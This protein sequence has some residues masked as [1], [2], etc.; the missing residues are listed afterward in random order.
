MAGS[1]ANERD[2]F[3]RAIVD[4]FRANRGR[5]GGPLAHTP[6]LLLHHIG[7]KSA[8]ERV[9]PLVCNR[10]PDGRY[11]IIASNGGSA[12][13]PAWYHNLRARPRAEVEV[14]TETF[15]VRAAELDGPERDAVWSELVAASPSLRDYQTRTQRQIPLL[16][17]TPAD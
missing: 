1:A 5:V 14:G 16:A 11:V 8:I 13:H 6:I 9:T 15:W 7:A 4:E 17:L 10:R 2:D 12:T 3:N